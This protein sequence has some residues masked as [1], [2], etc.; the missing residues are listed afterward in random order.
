MSGSEANPKAIV[1]KSALPPDTVRML[2]IGCAITVANVW[3]AQPLLASMATEWHVSQATMGNIAGCPLAGYATGM[4]L[5]VP[6]GDIVERRRL[7]LVFLTAIAAALFV[8]VSA[9]NITVFGA[10]AFVLGVATIVPQLII[11]YAVGLTEPK[12]RGAVVGKLMTGLLTGILLSRTIGGIIAEHFGWRAVYWCALAANSLLLVWFYLRLKECRPT[13]NLS[14]FQLVKSMFHLATHEPV[15]MSSAFFGMMTFACFNILWTVLSFFLA[16]APYFYSPQIVGS[17]GLMGMAGALA[18]GY[19]GKIA[20]YRGPMFPIGV[21]LI[22]MA[23]SFVILGISGTN[24]IGLSIGILLLDL[25]VQASQVSNMTRVYS[26]PA[27]NHSRLNTV[28][29]VSYF[30]G[31]TGGALLGTSAWTKFG[32]TGTCAS[33]VACALA[34]TALFLV[35]QLKTKK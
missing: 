17:F 13:I 8:I 18:A 9:A 28:Y 10:A 3:Y 14:Y 34:G 31:G 22:G 35:L 12:S 21:S 4:F 24:L 23:F 16:G 29:M 25:F 1:E 15:L 27:E 11:P 2:A 30:I 7:I 32:W 5:F 26:L 33:G 19:V 6:L 20:D